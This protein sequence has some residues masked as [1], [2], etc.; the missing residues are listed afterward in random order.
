MEL[1]PAMDEFLHELFD[2]GLASGCQIS[3]FTVPEKRAR[4][5][6]SIPAAVQVAQTLATT[7]N[8]Y[9]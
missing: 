3:L 9:F 6:S 4:R 8:V 7:Q 1:M 5:F 2:A